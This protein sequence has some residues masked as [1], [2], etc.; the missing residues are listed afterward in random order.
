VEYN[1]VNDETVKLVY[2]CGN[3]F[4]HRNTPICKGET[5]VAACNGHE[6]AHLLPIMRTK[7]IDAEPYNN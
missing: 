4:L 7:R 1:L 5:G 3:C 6:V 2:A